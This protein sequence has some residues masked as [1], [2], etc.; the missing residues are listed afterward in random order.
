MEPTR[1]EELGGTPD[2]LALI[3]AA[4]GER[5][6][7]GASARALAA[8]SV[9]AGVTAIGA[10]AAATTSGIAVLGKW[11]ATGV[12]LGAVSAGSVHV[13][14]RAEPSAPSPAAP[15]E[16][17]AEPT[18]T[19]TPV[20]AGVTTEVPASVEEEPAPTPNALALPPAASRPPPPL[21]MRS[22]TLG[23]ERALL[24]RARSALGAGATGEA[25]DALSRYAQ[26]FPSG[27]L[28]DEASVLH[29]E[30]SLARGD[31]SLAVT[32]C[33]AHLAARGDGPHA[34]RVRAMR[35]RALVTK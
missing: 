23:E 12:L 5:A 3:R 35:A 27:A 28:V 16:R 4:R 10:P 2:E 29:I 17:P 13:L 22:G 18:A 26:R 30:L 25:A 14:Y 33:D 7:A 19:A 15:V 20:T 21:A 24:E 11:L 1:I 34:A 32:L 6:P 8:L 9:V 31:T